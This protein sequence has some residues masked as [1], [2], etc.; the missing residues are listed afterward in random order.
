MI[1]VEEA[2]ARILAALEPLAP[3]TVALSQAHGRA[4]AE[5]LVARVTQPPSA[6]S[7][8]DGYAAR[9][10]DVARVPVVLRRVGE[11]PAGGAYEG[12]VGPGECVRIFT[13]GPVPAGA[14]AIVLQENTT[15]DGERI[16][17]TETAAAGKHIRV[18]G[19]DFKQGEIALRAGRA[20][21]A[22][23]VGLAAAI[24]RPWVKV[25]RRPRVAVLANGDEVVMPGDPIGANQIV[26]SNALALMGLIE[27]WGGVAVNLG[28][29]PDTA[30]GLQ[31]MAAGARGADVL[32]TTGGASVGDRDLVRHALGAKGLEIDFWQIAMRPGKPLMFGKLGDTPMLGL[33]GNPVSS[34]V[35]A[36][37][38]LRPALLKLQGLP[39]EIAFAEAQLGRDLKANDHRADF[40]R[41]SLARDDSG[42]PVATPFPVQDSSMMSLLAR[43]DCLVY[44]APNAAAARAGEVVPTLPLAGGLLSI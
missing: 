2:R 28:I 24:N 25:R 15:V 18:T 38:F 19:L 6:V 35:C 40:L 20:L 33:P 43:A 14:D 16:T 31:Q 22:R 3:E 37:L 13:G 36:L 11:A 8:M 17:V 26:S 30:E 29:A 9:A 21:T 41:A 4:L 1:P 42:T 39:T 12:T 23:D 10:A 44:R 7:A 27:A 34:F 5:D 32:V